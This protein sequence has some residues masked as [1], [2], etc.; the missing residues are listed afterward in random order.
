MNIRPS[1]AKTYK[2][3]R[4]SEG[5]GPRLLDFQ[6]FS[7]E[8]RGFPAKL[9]FSGDWRLRFCLGQF[10]GFLRG[11]LARPRFFRDWRLRFCL[12]DSGWHCP[13]NRQIRLGQTKLQ[14]PISIESGFG[15]ETSHQPTKLAH[16]KSQPPISTESGFGYKT[17]EIS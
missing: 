11:F 12:G 2:F 14:P 10:C 16:T 7:E 1:Q 9:R 15:Q 17:G 13:Q 6:L 8:F 5:F 3:I 4:E